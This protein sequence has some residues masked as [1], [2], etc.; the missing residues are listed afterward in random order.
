MSA[1]SNRGN[2]N[3]AI[4]Y[5]IDF[6]LKKSN[7]VM[8]AMVL[9]YDRV[10][11]KAKIQ[12]LIKAKYEINDGTFQYKDRAPIS[13]V[14]VFHLRAGGFD[15]DAPLKKGDTGW[16]VAADRDTYTAKQHNMK[17]NVA[18]N[19]GTQ[20]PTTD[21]IHS[22]GAGLFIPDSWCNTG[23]DTPKD[24][25]LTISAL[26][27]EGRVKMR[28]AIKPDKEVRITGESGDGSCLMKLSDLN[29]KTVSFR[30]QER[31]TDYDNGVFTKKKSI[32]LASEDYGESQFNIQEFVD[33]RIEALSS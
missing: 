23:S 11:H 10:A 14:T 28:I 31:V 12:P 4:G 29:K 17:M 32:V 18:D 27:S 20:V 26:D 7:S 5:L 15:I 22:F 2:F 24:D 30:E 16:I 1:L 9:E 33:A 21:E 6:I 19:E 13:S 25:S 8:P 3:G